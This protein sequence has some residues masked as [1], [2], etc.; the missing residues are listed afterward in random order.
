MK[1]FLLRPAGELISFKNYSGQTAKNFEK[2]ASVR[3]FHG[4][5]SLKRWDDYYILSLWRN[6]DEIVKKRLN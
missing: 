2:V 4:V 6:E 5:T 3:D 1:K